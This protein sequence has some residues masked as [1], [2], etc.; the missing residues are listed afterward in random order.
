MSR[1]DHLPSVDAARTRDFL[2][3]AAEQA[4]AL[5]AEAHREDPFTGVLLVEAH[6]PET[7]NLP[8]DWF[9]AEY[10]RENPHRKSWRLIEQAVIKD[11]RPNWRA[12][13]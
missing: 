1:L 9:E 12:A 4:L 2:R 6:W 3:R 11:G 7:F 5:Q 13:R 8:D 10:G